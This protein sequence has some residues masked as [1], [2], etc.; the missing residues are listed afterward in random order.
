MAQGGNTY[1]LYNVTFPSAT[2]TEIFVLDSDGKV[3]G[4]FLK[5]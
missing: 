1:Y 3:A 4:L 2:F 5:P